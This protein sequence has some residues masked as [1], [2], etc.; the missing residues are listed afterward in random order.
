M[1]HGMKAHPL[2]G[3]WCDM[4]KR[5]YN[6][7]DR[8]YKWY[9]AKGVYVCDEWLNDPIAFINWGINNGWEEGLHID[10]D[11][12]S[13]KLNVQPYYSPKTCCFVSKRVNVGDRNTRNAKVNTIDSLL[14]KTLYK[15]GNGYLLAKRFGVSKSRISQIVNDTDCNNLDFI[16]RCLP[17]TKGD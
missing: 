5:C 10:K 14:I 16:K 8:R 1:R 13:S 17:Q 11:T 6:K 7:N 3:V 15:R 12:L 2:Y 4:K 9:G